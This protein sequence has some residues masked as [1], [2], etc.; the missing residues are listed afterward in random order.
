MLKHI[1]ES[2][3]N[4][5]HNVVQIHSRAIKKSS[6]PSNLSETNLSRLGIACNFFPSP[7]NPKIFFILDKEPKLPDLEFPVIKYLTVLEILNAEEVNKFINHLER[8]G[9][10]FLVLM[11]SYNR[12]GIKFLAQFQPEETY[13][14]QQKMLCFLDELYIK[15]PKLPSN[16]LIRNFILNSDEGRY[17]DFY[18]K[19][20][21]FL[22]GKPVDR[23]FVDNILACQ[24]FDPRGYF[25]AEED[26]NIVG[27]LSIE[28]EPW[29]EKGNGF[30]YIYQIG[31]TESWRGSGLADVLLG[32][33]RDFAIE[34]GLN[35]IGVGV[36]K[37]NA[38]A[39]HFFKK[40]GFDVAYEVG[41]YLVGVYEIR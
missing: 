29:G 8:Q 23:S 12:A 1:P 26:G 41:G 38:P 33:A 31:V 6:F 11:E 35:R 30:G 17:A 34:Q 16:V 32:K 27:F 14:C 40:C 20:L 39:I 25:I 3:I 4:C 18:N 36:R 9:N 28:K 10:R 13:Y 22:A 5:L 21:G 7:A 15:E 24:S 2:A 19:V 37:S